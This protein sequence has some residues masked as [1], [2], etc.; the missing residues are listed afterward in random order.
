[1]KFSPKCRTMKLGIVNTIMGRSLNW[2]GADFGPQIRPGKIQSHCINHYSNY[3][4]VSPSFTDVLV[5]SLYF[6]I[7]HYLS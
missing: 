1:M 6:D 7:C 3:I 4:H 2:E 5:A